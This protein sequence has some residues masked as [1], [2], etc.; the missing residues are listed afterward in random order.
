MEALL[1]RVYNRHRKIKCVYYIYEWRKSK[2]YHP[3][4]DNHKNSRCMRNCCGSKEVEE[5]F[6]STDVSTRCYFNICKYCSGYIS[7]GCDTCT[8]ISFDKDILI[9]K[10]NYYLQLK[11][12]VNLV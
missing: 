5:P 6:D 7:T 4:F 9:F 11:F 3:F 12:I 1:R 2:Q 10:T 8:K